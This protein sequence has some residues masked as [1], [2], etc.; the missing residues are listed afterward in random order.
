[1]KIPV[2]VGANASYRTSTGGRKR[3]RRR[4]KLARSKRPQKILERRDQIA[5]GLRRLM[6]LYFTWHLAGL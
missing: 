2:S 3:M 4:I 5:A 1:M 6:V